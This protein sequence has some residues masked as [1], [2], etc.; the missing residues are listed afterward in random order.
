MQFLKEKLEKANT[1]IEELEKNDTYVKL[2]T[3]IE[4]KLNESNAIYFSFNQYKYLQFR[5]YDDNHTNYKIEQVPVISEEKGI[6]VS[7]QTYYI[8]LSGTKQYVDI[9]RKDSEETYIYC[10]IYGII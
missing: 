4:V 5:F 1:R 8:W 6:Y 7:S 10:D 3:K 2:K 9:R